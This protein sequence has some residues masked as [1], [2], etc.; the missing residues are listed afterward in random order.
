MFDRI[1]ERLGRAFRQLS[2]RGTITEANVREAMDEVRTALLEADVHV[3]VVHAFCNEVLQDALG[4][5]VTRSLRPGQ[6]MVG[7]V[8]RRLVELLG[9]PADAQTPP[10]IVRVSPPPTVVMVCG[11]QGSGKTTTCG[12]LA[13]HLARRSRRVLLCA[14]DLQRPAAVDQLLTVADQARAMI[15]DGAEIR[16][17]AEPDKVGQHGTVTGLAV[18]VC[19][20]ALELARRDRFDTLLLDTAGRLHIDDA[21][22]TELEQIRHALRPH[23]IL[24]VLDA[25]VGQ[26]AVVSARE[27]HRRLEFDG[28]VLTKFDSDTRGGAALSVK[29][30]TGAPIRFVGTGE[31]LDALEPFHPDR[32]AGR[33][34]GMGDIVSLVEKAQEQIDAEQAQELQD[35]L[36]RGDLTLDDFLRQLR[37]LRR[38]GPMKQLLGLLPG[39]GAMLKDVQIDDRELDRVEAI[40]N[41]MTREERARPDVVNAS[42]RRR[43]ALGSGTRPEQ[44]ARLLKQFDAMRRLS[45]Q[46]AQLGPAARS[47][48]VRELGAE[49]L[50]AVAPGLTRAPEF[51]VRGSTRADRGRFKSRKRRRR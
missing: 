34:L 12:K 36:V 13:V 46:M 45:R 19:L 27:F 32:M 5:E 4:R 31:R 38:M 51:R 47:R 42:R 2:G 1:G 24:F 11:L 7:I 3:D 44:V 28:V 20:R 41:S 14:A 8:H 10:D 48:A 43:I 35:R 40:I 18:G 49:G 21:L 30:V 37:L 6:E 26:D 17:Y 33:I 39:V 15:S 16:A 22:M 50:G 25:M 9:G 29:R 23:Q